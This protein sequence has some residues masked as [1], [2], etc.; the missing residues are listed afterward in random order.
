VERMHGKSVAPAETTVAVYGQRGQLTVWLSRF[1]DPFA[2][3]R[4]LD[5]MLRGLRGGDMPFTRPTQDRERPGRWTAVGGGRHHVFW[6]A[7]RSLYWLEGE[8]ATVFRA[9]E[10]LPPPSHGMLL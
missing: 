2:A 3:H 10:E 9:A 5:D 8:P 6:V 4:A 1:R 7:Q